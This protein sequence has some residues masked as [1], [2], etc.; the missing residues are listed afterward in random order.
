MTNGFEKSGFMLRRKN[1]AEFE[2]KTDN[3]CQYNLVKYVI[4]HLIALLHQPFFE[5]AIENSEDFLT[6]CDN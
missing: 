1:T 6:V 2:I 5:Q 3:V 4:F